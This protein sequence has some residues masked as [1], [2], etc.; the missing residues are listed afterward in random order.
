MLQLRHT[1]RSSVVDGWDYNDEETSLDQVPMPAISSIPH[2]K[3]KPEEAMC[4]AE[5][6]VEHAADNYSA[7]GACDPYRA[8]SS[9][10]YRVSPR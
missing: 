10:R 3:V 9:L 4:N 6:H 2:F 7:H 1:R 8:S 5:W